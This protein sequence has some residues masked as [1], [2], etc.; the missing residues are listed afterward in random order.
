MG[1]RI[2]AAG[3]VA[4]GLAVGAEAV[5]KLAGKLE[6]PLNS[7]AGANGSPQKHDHPDPSLARS[8]INRKGLTAGTRAPDFRLPQIGG[9]EL[10]L[11]SFRGKRLL[12]VFSDPN[13]GPCDELA[14]QLGN[15]IASGPT[16][17]S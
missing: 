12:L 13:C 4:S 6:R 16:C 14:P 7:I 17:R 3:R 10:S 8:K 15:C 11:D 9:R 2:D 1:Y 5:L